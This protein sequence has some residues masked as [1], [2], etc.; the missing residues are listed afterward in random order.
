MSKLILVRSR[1]LPTGWQRLATPHIGYNR[2]LPTTV[3]NIATVFNYFGVGCCVTSLDRPTVHTWREIILSR[4][5]DLILTWCCALSLARTPWHIR[6]VPLAVGRATVVC[7]H[8]TTRL[9]ASSNTPSPPHTLP[10]PSPPIP[11]LCSALSPLSTTHI[12]QY[13]FSTGSAIQSASGEGACLVFRAQGKEREGGESE[14][15]R[16][17]EGEKTENT[18][19]DKK[20]G[21]NERGAERY[22]IVHF[23]LSVYPSAVSFHPRCSIWAHFPV[24]G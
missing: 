14:I 8:R 19:Q 3:A 7:P 23:S 6:R 4:N 18:F 9:L 15:D 20:I 11:G 17:N 13:V 12:H 1:G 22:H 16:K 10:L 2:M 24:L 5:H 21:K